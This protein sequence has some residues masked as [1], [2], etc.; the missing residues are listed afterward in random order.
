[1]EASTSQLQEKH[2]LA[3]IFDLTE[4]GCSTAEV[5]PKKQVCRLRAFT[6]CKG[7]A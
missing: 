1:M 2:D 3:D 5:K 6:R 4:L 7:S